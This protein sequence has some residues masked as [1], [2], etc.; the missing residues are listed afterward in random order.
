LPTKNELGG[1]GDLGKK[2]VLDVYRSERE[3]FLE[4]EEGR[5]SYCAEDVL[6]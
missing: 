5:S 2:G 3:F 4:T 6:Y 1:P